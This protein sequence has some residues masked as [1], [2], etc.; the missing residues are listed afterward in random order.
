MQKNS[1]NYLI[2][3]ETLVQC[4]QFS[5]LGNPGR[6]GCDTGRFSGGRD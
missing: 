3:A 1:L 2:L 4:V 6:I 5:M